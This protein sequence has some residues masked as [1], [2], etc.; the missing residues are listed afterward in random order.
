MEKE[1]NA[2]NV[3]TGLAFGFA[4]LLSLFVLGLDEFVGLAV[5]DNILGTL[6]AFSGVFSLIAYHFSGVSTPGD[7]GF[8]PLE[9]YASFDSADLELISRRGLEGDH[10]SR[11]TRL[12]RSIW[13]HEYLLY[14]SYEKNVQNVTWA[15]VGV[16]ALLIVL[17][18][19]SVCLV[20]RRSRVGS[21][22]LAAILAAWTPIVLV[23]FMCQMTVYVLFHTINTAATFFV[24]GALSLF[25][26]WTAWSH[27]PS[28]DTNT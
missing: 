10:P 9:W 14:D 13:D 2:K 4:V 17:V 16:W 21:S 26:F 11:L 22:A 20:K 8:V 1:T 24:M 15:S 28:A 25:V 5:W 19:L 7:V 18:V 3:A 27:A 6:G 23:P 12:G